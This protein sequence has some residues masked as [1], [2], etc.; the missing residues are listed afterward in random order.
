MS[1]AEHIA[2]AARLADKLGNLALEQGDH[3]LALDALITAFASIA[4][5]HPCCVQESARVADAV[6][7]R[8]QQLASVR[9]QPT[10]QRIH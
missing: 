4:A 7:H 6:A 1:R 2:K 9:M 8:L 5:A 10:S 3:A